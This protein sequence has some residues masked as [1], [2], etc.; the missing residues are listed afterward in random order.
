MYRN[1]NQFTNHC[2]TSSHVNKK[3][4]RD[5]KKEVRIME[6]WKCDENDGLWRTKTQ[7]KQGIL[8]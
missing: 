3:W 5:G 1:K 4:K 7:Q 8:E 6:K 2:F